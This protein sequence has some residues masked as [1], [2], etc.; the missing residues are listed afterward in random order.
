MSES[1]AVRGVICLSAYSRV[2]TYMVV[3]SCICRER[4]R[5]LFEGLRMWGL[6]FKT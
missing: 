2:N 4:E 3:G 5:V 1:F 6:R